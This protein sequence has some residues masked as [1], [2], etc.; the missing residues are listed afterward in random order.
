MLRSLKTQPLPLP[1]PPPPPPPPKNILKGVKPWSRQCHQS[2]SQCTKKH[3]NIYQLTFQREDFLSWSN[4]QNN[5]TISSDAKRSQRLQFSCQ[6]DD[7]QQSINYTSF[8]WHPKLFW[9]GSDA[10]SKC[11]SMSN[12][13]QWKYSR[14]HSNYEWLKMCSWNGSELGSVSGS[15]HYLLL[16]VNA[17]QSWNRSSGLDWA[18]LTA[19]RVEMWGNAYSIM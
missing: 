9:N 19:L 1:P 2:Y 13:N 3:Y 10:I 7:L 11:R 14:N 16:R 6:K 17:T 4:L 12:C 18:R 8:T 15:L 5:L